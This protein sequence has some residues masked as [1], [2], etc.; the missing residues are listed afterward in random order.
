MANITIK[1]VDYKLNQTIHEETL[2]GNV[3]SVV[4]VECL[5]MTEYG[6]PTVIGE[7]NINTGVSACKIGDTVELKVSADESKNVVNFYYSDANRRDYTFHFCDYDTKSII[8][9]Q[10]VHSKALEKIETP[11]R[12]ISGYEF[13]L[14][15]G[16]SINQ[17]EKDGNNYKTSVIT[18]N[19]SNSNIM[20]LFYRRERKF[21]VA[22]IDKSTE[23]E[24]GK[25]TFNADYYKRFG[26]QF[27]GVIK[28]P[29]KYSIAYMDTDGYTIDTIKSKDGTEYG[30]INILENQ[31]TLIVSKAVDNENEN[32]IAYCY[33]TSKDMTL[34][35][36][37]VDK[38]GVE[39]K[40]TSV[41]GKIGTS[42]TATLE[43]S[44]V[45]DEVEYV[46]IFGNK[47]EVV[48]YPSNP[49][50]YANYKVLNDNETIMNTDYAPARIKFGTSDPI[51]LYNDDENYPIY[52]ISIQEGFTTD[53]FIGIGSVFIPSCSVSIGNNC[54]LAQK[55]VIF[56][57]EFNFSED[58]S[59]DKWE[60][61]GKFYIN[62]QPE[63]TDDSTNFVGQG[64]LGLSKN[65]FSIVFKNCFKY[66][67]RNTTGYIVPYVYH[68]YVLGLV[69]E[70][71]SDNKSQIQYNSMFDSI[72]SDKASGEIFR[73]ILNEATYYKKN[74]DVQFVGFDNFKN[75][76]TIR[77]VYPILYAD[78]EFGYNEIPVIMREGIDDDLA[79]E[80]VKTFPNAKQ[81]EN[82]TSKTKQEYN[83]FSAID[84]ISAIASILAS[85]VVETRGKLQ[86]ISSKGIDADNNVVFTEYDYAENSVKLGEQLLKANITTKNAD[87]YL[88]GV[89]DKYRYGLDVKT[90]EEIETET[91]FELSK[92]LT[93]NGKDEIEQKIG[94]SENANYNFVYENNVFWHKAYE[95]Q[96]N[97][98]LRGEKFPEYYKFEGDFIGYH[99]QLRPGQ[100]IVISRHG[101][102]YKTIVGRVSYSWDGGFMTHVEAPADDEIIGNGEYTSSGSSTSGETSN[103]TSNA[104]NNTS[105]YSYIYEKINS[106]EKQL[107]E[108]KITKLDGATI[109]DSSITNSN[110]SDSAIS[111]SKISKSA[112]TE[113]KIADSSITNSKIA[114]STIDGSKIKFSTFE[115]GVIKGSSIDG[116]TFTDGQIRGSVLY[117]IPFASID[118]EFVKNLTADK[119]FV[120][121]FSAK[122]GEF[123]LLA[124]NMA[125]IDN[126][127]INK[128]KVA[129]LF[130]EMGLISSAVIS[131]GHVTG[132]L[133]SVEVNADKVTAG[134]FLAERLILKDEDGNYHML[135]YDEETEKVVSSKL[136][137]NILKERTV[138]ADHMVAH[139]ITTNEITTE[140]LIGANGWINLANATFNYGNKISFDGEHLVIDAES[141]TAVTENRYAS[142]GRV[143]DLEAQ[144]QGSKE[145]FTGKDEPTMYNYPVSTWEKED[146][147][148]HV[149]CMYYDEQGNAY[150]FAYETLEYQNDVLLYDN[151]ALWQYRWIK[152]VDSTS[153]QALQ[154]AIEAVG[155][156]N[157]VSEDLTLNY[158]NTKEVQRLI[159]VSGESLESRISTD[160]VTKA[161]I[162]D[163]DGNLLGDYS[164]TKKLISDLKQTDSEISQTLRGTYE[165]VVGASKKYATNND[166]LTNYTKTEE[167]KTQIVEKQGSIGLAVDSVTTEK[168]EQIKIGGVNL[169]EDSEDLDT[170]H[171]LFNGILSVNGESLTYKTER[172]VA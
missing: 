26:N 21:N 83:E 94:N 136:D 72:Y 133:D 99:N 28:A 141:I 5:D 150:R 24:I 115:N 74:T 58:V 66:A 10:I 4:K 2:S 148:N 37:Y 40:E 80:I 31:I 34:T 105:N 59:D 38:N 89:S 128:E 51:Y 131:E 43:E 117:D 42:Y 35:I 140:N 36:K 75:S 137:G 103:T 120:D 1:Y 44:I 67:N 6:F 13:L 47:L 16:T 30:N 164:T 54:N 15:A 90:E 109:A 41:V 48:F 92:A 125:N 52:N 170:H 17:E 132:F 145:T 152:Q 98:T 101:K 50:V 165:T 126:A 108:M 3:D 61:F 97:Q 113:S 135:T 127:N 129:E 159:D 76:P 60:T 29:S 81:A 65:D 78:N 114:D 57:L 124:A 32:I 63:R 151:E 139:T 87:C 82:S 64:M 100:Q 23:K 27:I 79:D 49:I 116:S 106:L 157:G 71:S 88:T 86:F 144:I 111:N 22:F 166:L 53:D 168:V 39:L 33:D 134:T 102:R 158:S 110:I 14:F 153:A 93:L 70:Y 91:V 130:A 84:Y 122:I 171:R 46:P 156:A 45:V 20:Y 73:D 119:A 172:L 142:N 146:Y 68:N 107:K 12:Q 85:N 25:Q 155:L 112:I 9:T 147:I 167:L 77:N 8:D 104:I 95:S 7:G 149:G 62:E 154:K 19:Y 121:D 18:S 55:G 143:D 160:Y 56:E 69:G 169:V 163:K 118:E 162:S 161:S 138:T 11:V 96:S 123:D